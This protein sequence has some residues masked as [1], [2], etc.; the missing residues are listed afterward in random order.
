MAPD[1][2]FFNVYPS[3]NQGVSPPGGYNR[4]FVLISSRLSGRR[5]SRRTEAA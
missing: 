1:L 5:T 2:N 3:E 4:L